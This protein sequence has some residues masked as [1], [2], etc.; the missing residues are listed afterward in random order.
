MPAWSLGY[1][2]SLNDAC[3]SL[4]LHKARYILLRAPE[5]SDWHHSFGCHLSELVWME[6]LWGRWSRPGHV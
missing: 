2:T 5:A 6:L 4:I 1:I 3:M